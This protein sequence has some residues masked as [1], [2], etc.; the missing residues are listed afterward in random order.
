[1][2]C[3]YHLK[4]SLTAVATPPS[5]G[6][7]FCLYHLKLSL[8]AACCCPWTLPLDAYSAIILSR[9][10]SSSAVVIL[11]KKNIY[12]LR[13]GNFNR[14]GQTSSSPSNLLCTSLVHI[15]GSFNFQFTF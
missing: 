8:T 7:I 6:R 12:F 1:I 13:R 14:G 4:L 5:P 10:T 3:L 15:V 2:F 11:F 9:P